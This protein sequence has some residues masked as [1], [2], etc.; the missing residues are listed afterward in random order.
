[1]EYHS[2]IEYPKF[3]FG[4]VEGSTITTICFKKKIK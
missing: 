4:G 3:K 1:M 2:E